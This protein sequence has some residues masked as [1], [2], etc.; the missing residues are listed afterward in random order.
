MG[1]FGG[2]GKVLGGHNKAM[3]GTAGWDKQLKK[4][5]KRAIGNIEGYE[6]KFNKM[7]LDQLEKFM[8]NP[9][10]IQDRASYQFTR[11]QGLEA[12]ARKASATGYRGS[13]NVQY[14]LVDYASGLA[15]QEYG[16]EFDRLFNLSQLAY[17][18]ASDMA[19]LNA[20]RGRDISQGNFQ[21][22]SQERAY[23]HEVGMEFLQ[24]RG[25]GKGGKPQG[26]GGGGGGS[27]MGGSMSNF[28]QNVY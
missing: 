4:G 13:G 20:S 23:Q 14:D 2:I 3:S 12:I 16:N 8:Q 18:A 24:M 17:G 11:D 27:S 1:L 15:S 21:A 28:G 5:Y 7:G 25:G 6:K 10:Y 19:G 9:N 22:M 26:G